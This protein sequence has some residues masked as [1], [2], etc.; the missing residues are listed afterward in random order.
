MQEGSVASKLKLQ[1]ELLDICTEQAEQMVA[2][3]DPT[4]NDSPLTVEEFQQVVQNILL[5][6]SEL[7]KREPGVPE[8]DKFAVKAN[9]LICG[10]FEHAAKGFFKL[11]NVDEDDINQS[12]VSG[13]AA[14]EEEVRALGNADVI[15]QLGYILRQRAN[16]KLCHNGMRDRG[17]VGM[18]LQ[19]FVEHENS[20][21]AELKE[22]EVVAL[23][24]YTTSAFLQ[25]N[26]P[27]RDQERISSGRP[28]PL[29]VTVM[30]IARGIKKLRAIG[31]DSEDAT[32]TVVLWRGMKNIRPT[33]SFSTKGGTEVCVSCFLS[34]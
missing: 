28:H 29:P 14:I 18:R 4:K 27:L 13:V 26:R 25:I 3:Y 12:I 16:E 6:T 20:R 10:E 23:R 11:L 31:A 2:Q 34:L 24:L 1:K 9:E 15:Q 17:H 19:D 7:V 8:L 21:T 22:A 32:G 30:L 5:G 33:D